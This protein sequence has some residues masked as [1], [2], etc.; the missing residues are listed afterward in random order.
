MDDESPLEVIEEES[1]DS[2]A[3]RCSLA[4]EC[5]SFNFCASSATSTISTCTLT[6]KHPQTKGAKIS[7]KEGCRNY[8]KPNLRPT[9]PE[10]VIEEPV[11]ETPTDPETPS[12]KKKISGRKF[13]GIVFAMIFTG[14][15]LGVVGQLGW[16]KYKEKRETGGFGLDVPSVRWVRQKDDQE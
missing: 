5:S 16:N 1:A 15:I 12:K 6:N 3:S 11:P 10:K 4:K 14:L 9:K 2:C 7:R 8:F 13:T